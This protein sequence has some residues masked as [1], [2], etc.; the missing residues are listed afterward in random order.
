MNKIKN[1]ENLEESNGQNGCSSLRW[2]GRK[3]IWCCEVTWLVAGWEVDVK[4]WRQSRK[5][6]TKWEAGE[7]VKTW[8][9]SAKLETEHEIGD[10][11]KLETVQNRRH[12]EIGDSA[13]SLYIRD[14]LVFS[15]IKNTEN[16]FKNTRYQHVLLY[17]FRGIPC[18]VQHVTP[19]SFAF[20][21]SQVYTKR[22]PVRSPMAWERGGGLS[23]FVWPSISCG[24]VM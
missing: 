24:S 5:L 15:A 3:E 10:S 18:T 12:H 19:V 17:S 9:R 20:V 1:T 21:F 7:R 6:E 13:K 22:M 16:P 11:A 2:E 23:D 8:R 4:I 14:R